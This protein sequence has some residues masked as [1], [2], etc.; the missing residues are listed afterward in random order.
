[1]ISLFGPR[2]GDYCD[3]HSRRQFLKIGGL[4]LGGLSLPQILRAESG[5]GAGQSKPKQHKAVI[6]IYLVGG[7]FVGIAYQPFVFMLIGL[8][9]ALWSYLKRVDAPV[10]LPVQR[11]APVL[12][13]GTA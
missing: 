4:A 3:G 6:M 7:L 10:R 11:R 5:G 8:Q 12:R 9:C 2:N 13:T 1:M